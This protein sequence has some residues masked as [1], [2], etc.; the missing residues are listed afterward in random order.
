MRWAFAF[1]FAAAMPMAGA[2]QWIRVATPDFELYTTAGEKAGREA[3]EHF[4]RVRGF[5]QRASPVRSSSD[6]P[7]RIVAFSAPD[8]FRS[9]S[10]NGV[11]SAFF[12]SDAQRDYIVMSSLTEADFPIAIHE[13]MH[14]VVRHSG[15]KLPVWLNEGWADLY[16]T[17][18]PMGKETAVGDLLPGRM[19]DLE[20]E[21]WLDFDTLTS[22]DQHS[23]IYN[24]SARV[25]IFYAE[26]W[27]LTHML[28]LSPEYQ[29]NFGKFVLALNGGKS[30]SEA[31]Q[32]AWGR[33]PGQVFADL[34]AYFDRKKLFGRAFA[35][36]FQKSGDEPVLAALSD[37]DARLALADLSAA[38]NRIDAAGQEY[39]R[40]D[41]EQPGRPDVA[42]SIGFLALRQGDR[43]AARAR[44]EQAFSEG[45]AVPQLCLALADL[46]RDA[47]LPPAKRIAPL[48]RALQAKPDYEAARFQLGLA[49]VETR[50]FPAAITTLMRIPTV[51]PDQATALFM[52]LAY[53]KLQ[54]GELDGARRDAEKARRYVRT[55]KEQSGVD[56]ILKLADARSKGAWAA[57]AGEKVQRVEG[58]VRRIDCAPGGNRLLLQSAIGLM[59][60]DLPPADA[61]EFTRSH[62][63]TLKVACGQQMALP[64]VVEYAP[65]PRGES[66]SAGVVRRLEY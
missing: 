64:A 9:Y 56:Q 20:R 63:G 4:E 60:F 10:V 26:S 29:D 8:R 52:A 30:A 51:T 22:V 50:D 55:P 49:Q 35:A 28:Y 57:Q 27:A 65:P 43:P 34:H 47:G 1:L 41:K 32:I 19:R 40:L 23:P 62:G 31:I 3:M 46:E 59:T 6:F 33:T 21:P 17:M 66:G 16:S 53:A 18:R 24:E 48:E 12:A 15:L 13:Y 44:F 11:A 45:S 61:V 58:T 54:T 7:V 2:D 37:F 38:T 25:G 36:S 42:G 39:A 14:L 5:F